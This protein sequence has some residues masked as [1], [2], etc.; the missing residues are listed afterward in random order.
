MSVIPNAVLWDRFSH[1]DDDNLATGPDNRFFLLAAAHY[2][3]KNIQLA[4]DAFSIVRA[5]D[6]D[7]ELVLTGQLPE[8]LVGTGGVALE[9]RSDGVRV[10]GYVEDAELGRLYRQCQATLIPT[11]YEGF[12]LPAIEALGLGSQVI[13]S[14]VGG[15]REVTRD[16]QALTANP[17]SVQAWVDQMDRVRSSRPR[18]NQY[19]ISLARERYGA[20]RI[21]ALWME[22]LQ[23]A[24]A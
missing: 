18:Q 12:G 19:V 9:L 7:V 24:V 13:H 3:H 21:G 10:V 2:P 16:L 14:N 20:E 17:Y 5:L 22:A 15:L 8:N 11:L 4:L 1:H 6:N 23:R